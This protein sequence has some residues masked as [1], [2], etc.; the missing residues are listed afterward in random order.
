[1]YEHKFSDNAS[2]VSG[3]QFFDR[4][5]KSNDRGDHHVKQIGSFVV[6][7]QYLGAFTLSPALRFDWDERGGSEL[8]PQMNFSYRKNKFLL[9]GSAG[10]T[11]RH[12]DFTER[13]NN[14]NKTLV[15]SGRIGNPAL[16]AE[17]SFSYELGA[18]FFLS[19]SLKISSTYFQR[20]HD[21]LIDYVTTAYADMPRK[22]NLSPTGKYDLAKNISEVNTKGFE[23]DVQ[24][25]KQLNSKQ[26]FIITSGFTWLESKSSEGTPSIYVSSHARLLTNFSVHY[27][28]SRFNIGVNGLYKSRTPQSSAPI[29]AEV[30]KNYF[31][32]NAK[33]EG[34]VIKKMLSLFVE[35]DNVFDKEYSDLLGTP[36]PG[37][38]LMGGLKLSLSK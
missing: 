38:W 17:R 10:K 16:T 30:T 2:L 15:T 18:D 11:I 32:L 37:R 19:E 23:T 1:V 36:M 6:W 3:I 21:D 20:D 28:T 34:F 8:I 29:K 24:F 4:S 33:A 14:Y 35:V 7:Q 25:V 26:Q 13:Y 9:R 5:I 27:S 12:A 22:T 31:L